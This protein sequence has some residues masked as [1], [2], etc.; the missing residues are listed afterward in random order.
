MSKSLRFTAFA[1]DPSK[2][3]SMLSKISNLD[4]DK[5]TAITGLSSS[6]L[7]ISDN[8]A[9]YLLGSNSK[10]VNRKLLAIVFLQQWNKFWVGGYIN[11]GHDRCLFVEPATPP[12]LEVTEIDID[13]RTFWVRPVGSRVLQPNNAVAEAMRYHWINPW[14]GP[15][16]SSSG[17]PN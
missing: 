4:D 5:L 11:S 13:G 12:W 15:P 3:S 8:M 2:N 1:F 6:K 9:S 10:A 14:N 17:T 16:G 7:L